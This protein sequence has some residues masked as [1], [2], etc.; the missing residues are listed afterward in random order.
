[1]SQEEDKLL[2][3]SYDGIQEF[4]NPMPTWWVGL[5]VFTIIWGIVY[6]FYF[7]ITGVGNTQIEDSQQELAVAEQKYGGGDSGEE[8]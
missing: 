5:F 4:D 3:H 6:F 2:D 1:M 7:E 8:A